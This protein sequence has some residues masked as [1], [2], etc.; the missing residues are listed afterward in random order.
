MTG[1]TAST[2]IVTAWIAEIW[3]QGT[4][5]KCLKRLCVNFEGLDRDASMDRINNKIVNLVQQLTLEEEA[6]DVDNLVIFVEDRFSDLCWR[7]V[8]RFHWVGTAATY[9][10]ARRRKNRWG[11]EVHHSGVGKSFHKS[12]KNDVRITENGSQHWMIGKHKTVISNGIL[13]EF[14]PQTIPRPPR[15]PLHRYLA[16]EYMAKKLLH[17]PLV[18][19][20]IQMKMV[21]FT[22]FPT[23]QIY[24]VCTVPICSK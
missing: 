2:N 19:F 16:L 17:H 12:E 11:T 3:M 22:V 8:S 4:W 18:L 20:L 21:F 1:I 9:R 15:H 10:G 13:A 6:Q 24:M 7:R 23:K 14:Q 5:N